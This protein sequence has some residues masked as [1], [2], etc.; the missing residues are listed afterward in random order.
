M[1]EVK[2]NMLYITGDL[3]GEYEIAK[4]STANFHGGK[5]LCKKDYIIILGDFGLVWENDGESKQEK[6]WLDWLENKNWTTLFIDGNHEH[7]PR[8]R[9]YPE[10]EMFGDTVGIIRP[11]VLHLKKRGGIYTIP[12]GTTELKCWCFGGAMSH[13]K[14]RRRDGISWWREELP[15]DEEYEYGMKTLADVENNVDFIFTHEAC[16]SVLREIYGSLHNM[17]DNR[18]T[19][20]LPKYFQRVA[21]T[22]NFKAWYFGHHHI[23]V[24]LGLGG[25]VFEGLRGKIVELRAED[26]DTI[27][28]AW[29]GTRYF[30]D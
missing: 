1:R 24:K 18:T 13:D 4:L 7:F 26:D 19:Y 20:E 21:E 28:V 8:L 5:S 25:K 6:Y 23:N 3:H 22:T 27:F 16:E 2:E 11:S 9:G 10:T 17:P 12:D 15:S 14:E 29:D 30:I